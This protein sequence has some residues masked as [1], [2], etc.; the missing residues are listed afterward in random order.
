MLACTHGAIS[1]AVLQETNGTDLLSAMW[2]A[3][4]SA[5]ALSHAVDY[6]ALTWTQ[7]VAAFIIAFWVYLLVAL[8]AAYVLSLYLSSGTIIYFLMRREVDAT[9][10]DEVYFRPRRRGVR[11]LRRRAR[12]PV[13][14]PRGPAAGSG[15]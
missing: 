13:G 7:G 10:L 8:L 2:P 11:R 1:L 14:R 4:A 9:D 3:P 6:G 5:D 12:G 15:R